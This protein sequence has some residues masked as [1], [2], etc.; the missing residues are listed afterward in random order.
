[1]LMWS[2]LYRSENII[3][4]VN[5]PDWLILIKV[6]VVNEVINIAGIYYELVVE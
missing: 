4:I 2:R 6:S 5:Y 1:M 3:R